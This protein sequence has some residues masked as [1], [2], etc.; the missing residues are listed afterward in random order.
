[1]GVALHASS[2]VSAVN[3]TSAFVDTT[4]SGNDGAGNRA[5]GTGG[6]IS[7]TATI[8]ATNN[9]ASIG[10]NIVAAGGV[11]LVGKTPPRILRPGLGP[12]RGLI[13]HPAFNVP[14]QGDTLGTMLYRIQHPQWR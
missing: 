3:Q 11:A 13:S 7:F 5:A 10:A 14:P 4:A 9:W 8:T 1:M 12:T 2:T 6:A